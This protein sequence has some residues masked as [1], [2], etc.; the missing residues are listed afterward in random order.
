MSV[1]LLISPG[2]FWFCHWYSLN[3]WHVGS[4]FLVVVVVVVVVAGVVVV[5]SSVSGVVT[6]LSTHTV[7][8]AAQSNTCS[9]LPSAM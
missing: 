5:A 4:G 3:L 7:N 2:T 6:L 1:T 8:R 9:V